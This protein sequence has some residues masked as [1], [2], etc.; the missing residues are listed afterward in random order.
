MRHVVDF[1]LTILQFRACMHCTHAQRAHRLLL[2]ELLNLDFSRT[3]ILYDICKIN[4]CLTEIE[5]RKSCSL[6]PGATGWKKEEKNS[7]K[8]LLNTHWRY[9]HP[10]THIL[11]QVEMKLMFDVREDTCLPPRAIHVRLFLSR[12]WFAC[13]LAAGAH[14]HA[15]VH[16]AHRNFINEFL[17]M[18]KPL[19]K[20]LGCHQ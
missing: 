15:F 8:Y 10:C 4:K 11:V 17:R 6:M 9:T 12:Y 3:R 13:R 1:I 5:W 16:N 18:I 19:T 2:V 7:Y 20:Y 14:R